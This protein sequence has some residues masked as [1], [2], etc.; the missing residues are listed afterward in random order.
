MQHDAH[1]LPTRGLLEYLIILSKRKVFILLNVMTITVLAAVVS[2]LLPKTYRSSATIMPPKN[3]GGMNLLS[4][5]S[6]SLMK[7]FSPLRALSGSLSPDMYG[8]VSILKSRTLM[9]LVVNQFDLKQRYGARTMTRAI[10]TLKT[11]LDYKVNE[12]TPITLSA[13]DVAIV[14]S[15]SAN[16]FTMSF[17]TGM[18]AWFGGRFCGLR[19]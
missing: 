10:E 13:E 17:V 18:S 4:M 11:N 3:A 12:E 8:Y 16:S 2:F 15:M 5:S 19:M 1:D 9:E 6:S 7:Q 14:A